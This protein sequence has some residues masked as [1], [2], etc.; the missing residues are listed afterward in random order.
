VPAD[1]WAKY[2]EIDAATDRDIV[3]LTVT[4]P[5]GATVVIDHVAVGTAPVKTFV[6]AGKRLVAVGAGTTRGAAFITVHGKPLSFEVS[7]ADRASPWKRVAGQVSAWQGA[8]PPS[9]VEVTELLTQVN[10]RF[11]VVLGER[12]TAALWVRAPG[13]PAAKLVIDGAMNDPLELGAGVMA[14]VEAW[15]GGG[16]DPD[17]PLAGTDDMVR[18]V[19]RK[20]DTKWWVYAVIGG[21]LA[22]GAVTLFAIEVGDDRQII[23]LTF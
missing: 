11:A 21:A 10:V 20:E 6:H 23:D 18:E 22:A 7:A 13:E 4:A 12:N 16:L 8:A 5:A 17:K 3:E 2:P 15:S 19:T 1:V 9:A 14:R